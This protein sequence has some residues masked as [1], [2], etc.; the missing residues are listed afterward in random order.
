MQDGGHA[1][2]GG[3]VEG[4]EALLVLTVHLCP[5]D[6]QQPHHVS[7]TWESHMEPHGDREREKESKK[8]RETH[9][10]THTHNGTKIDRYGERGKRQ[11]ERYNKR[12]G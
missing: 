9:T 10:H 7:L 5:S 12:R 8:E 3:R 4:G 11:I 1:A 6:H 2:G